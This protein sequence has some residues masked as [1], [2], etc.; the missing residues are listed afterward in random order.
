MEEL[1]QRLEAMEAT[2]VFLLQMEEMEDLAPEEAA[3]GKMAD[4]AGLGEEEEELS[5]L[6]ED[7]AATLEE[8]EAPLGFPSAP[9]EEMEDLEEEEALEPEAMAGRAGLALE[10]ARGKSGLEVRVFMQAETEAA[11]R[12]KAAAAGRVSAALFFIEMAALLH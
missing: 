8:E 12:T 5:I 6:P 1:E 2:E 11:G 7:L 10:E 3:E 9:M 4:K